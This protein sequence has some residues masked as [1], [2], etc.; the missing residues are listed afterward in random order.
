MHEILRRSLNFLT[1]AEAEGGEEDEIFER[2]REKHVCVSAPSWSEF[3]EQH[4]AV[5]TEEVERRYAA[6]HSA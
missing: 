6:Q 3:L 2:L 4:A 5:V 1:S